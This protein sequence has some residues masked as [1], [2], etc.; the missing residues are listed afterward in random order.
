MCVASLVNILH[1]SFE[2]DRIMTGCFYYVV[3]QNCH[4]DIVALRH[5]YCIIQGIVFSKLLH[6]II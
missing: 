3:S 5:E 1:T 4:R 2:N 6:K